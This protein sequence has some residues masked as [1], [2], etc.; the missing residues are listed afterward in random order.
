MK[1]LFA[2]V[3]LACALSVPALAGEIPTCSPVAASGTQPSVTQSSA[4]VTVVL[5]ILSLVR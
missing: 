5:T 3:L 4:V 2:A 1:R